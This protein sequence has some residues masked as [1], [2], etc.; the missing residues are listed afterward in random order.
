M[1]GKLGANVLR[2]DVTAGQAVGVE[3]LLSFLVVL[4]VCSATDTDRKMNDYGLGPL[5]V[6]FAY[7]AAHFMGVS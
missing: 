4:T 5:M 1:R 2:D 3:A 7:S 6:G